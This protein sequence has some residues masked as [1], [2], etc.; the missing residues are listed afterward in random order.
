[1]NFK[2]LSISYLSL[3]LLSGN[4]Y[5]FEPNNLNSC[6]LSKE[7]TNNYEPP[8]FATSNNLLRPSG[9]MEIYCG[10]KILL[11]VKLLDI[12]C[13]PISDAKIY[14]WQVG[15]DGKYP[16]KPLRKKA[17]EDLIN[18]EAKS[19]FVGHGTATTDN[20]GNSHFLTILPPNKYG[21]GFINLRISHSLYGEFQTKLE[22]GK[23]SIRKT[24]NYDVVEARITVPWEN[25]RRSY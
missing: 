2:L 12:S 18:T 7:A 16:Y 20:L 5:G 15:C 10:E 14:I 9:M 24:K 19:S 22:I 6:N 1:M 25:I 11:K 3:A 23:D 17:K 4:A 21:E 13:V 8:S